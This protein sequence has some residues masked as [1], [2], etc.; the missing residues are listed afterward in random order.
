[1]KI[2]LK[3]LNVV[4]SYSLRSTEAGE[5]AYTFFAFGKPYQTIE[6]FIV[7]KAL[8]SDVHLAVPSWAI[9]EIKDQKRRQYYNDITEYRKL[10]KRLSGLPHIGS[11]TESEGE[12][13]CSD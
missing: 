13:D 2:N 8:T 11:L 1:M 5:V 9:E 10:A 4:D 12:F 3:A 7:E 6:E